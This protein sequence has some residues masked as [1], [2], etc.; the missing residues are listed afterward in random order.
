LIDTLTLRHYSGPCRT[1]PFVTGHCLWANAKRILIRSGERIRITL[2]GHGADL[3]Q[4]ATGSGIHEW[5]SA[6]GTTTN[7]PDAPIRFGG[8]V[9]KGYVTLDV[10]AAP[11]HGLGNRTVTVKWLTGNETLF[12]KI[13]ASCADVV[14]AAYREPAITAAPSSGGTGG[15][16]RPPVGGGSSSDPDPKPVIPNLLPMLNH[17]TTLTRSLT[18][19]VIATPLGGMT[20]VSSFFANGLT[21]NVV[22]TVPVPKLTW[23]VSG[24]NNEAADSEFDV[25]LIDVTDEN[26]PLVLD[27]LSL[28]QGFPEHTP[29]VTKDN[30]PGRLTS[31][32]VIKNPIFKTGTSTT[33]YIGCFTAPGITQA[34]DPQKLLL[35]VD[36]ADRIDEGNRENDNELRF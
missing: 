20:E 2:Y 13:V 7:Y 34:L 12:F 18:G 30:Y 26:N 35:V 11:A 5:I 10:R 33:E 6:R 4:D 28:P 32:R 22:A 36:S 27:T 1:V 16:R 24:V 23:G 8:F 21:D 9:S 19:Q 17:P 31:I 29:L 25:Q 14:G 15:E 3:A